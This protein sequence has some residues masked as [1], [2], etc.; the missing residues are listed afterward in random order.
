MKYKQ[1]KN[2]CQPVQKQRQE[3]KKKKNYY[4]ARYTQTR[5]TRIIA[6]LYSLAKNNI[7]LPW[8]EK[9]RNY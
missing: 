8:R 9:N 4:K 2:F 7:L 5:I 1:K 3:E 6:E